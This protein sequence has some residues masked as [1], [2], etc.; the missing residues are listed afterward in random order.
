MTHPDAGNR[1]EILARAE[2][3]VWVR[4]RAEVADLEALLGWADAHSGDPQAEPGAV[5]TEYGGP[6]L[7]RVGGEGTPE[8]ADLCFAEIAVARRVGEVATRNTT[9]DALDLRHRLPQLWEVVRRLECPA[10]VGGRVARM[11]RPLSQAA[12]GVVDT[13]VAAAIAESPGRI[14][15]IAEATV[16]EAD[17]DAHR[18][19]IERARRRRGVWLSGR[20]VGDLVDEADP[21]AGVR[22][23]T[24]RLDEAD[25]V[26]LDALIEDLARPSPGMV[27]TT[28]TIRPA[29]ISSVPRRW[30]CSPVPSGRWRC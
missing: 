10:W 26:E 28:P 19:R 8:V 29:T 27:T 18:E 1:R 5:P 30:R 7:V 13:A 3:E 14:L 21:V 11:S 16:I 4:R 17:Q 22:T 12:V 6:R 2:S 25:A 23:L 15:A 9:A 20:R 24:G